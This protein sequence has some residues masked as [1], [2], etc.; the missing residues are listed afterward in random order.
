[1]KFLNDFNRKS[2]AIESGIDPIAFEGI[3]ALNEDKTKEII[4]PVADDNMGM[5]Q[6]GYITRE[7]KMYACHYHGH[8]M[9]AER[10][11]RSEAQR[12]SDSFKLIVLKSDDE[13]DWELLAEEQ[14]WLKLSKSIVSGGG[15]MFMIKGKPS[16][17]QR[18]TFDF[19]A[20][21]HGN[22]ELQEF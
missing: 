8:K 6:F 2:L 1:M 3:N 13:T 12:G 9:L 22:P 7:G 11:F 19:W 15:W 14:R 20:S 17:K 16:R 5:V 4:D 18:D 10:I 21:H